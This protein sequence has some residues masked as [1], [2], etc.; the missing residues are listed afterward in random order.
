MTRPT[1]PPDDVPAVGSTATDVEPGTDVEPAGAAEPDVVPRDAAAD[2]DSA[3]V[4]PA[5][6]DA[7]VSDCRVVSCVG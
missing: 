6:V 3:V 5:V 4:V 7:D 2:E 1:V